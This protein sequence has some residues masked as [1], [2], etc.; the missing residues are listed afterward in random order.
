MPFLLKR[1]SNK[2]KSK[3]RCI[4]RPTISGRNSMN[5][6]FMLKSKAKLKTWVKLSK[7]WCNKPKLRW[8][9]LIT[10]A[11]LPSRLATSTRKKWS[12][13]LW[14]EQT[15][16]GIKLVGL[17]VSSM[18]VVSLKITT[19]RFKNLRKLKSE[20]KVLLNGIAS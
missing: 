3:N 10:D 12:K 16:I 20:L 8:T 9:R 13:I 2:D 18:E 1:K 14:R 7:L 5:L 6:T 17:Q 4:A 11:L 15:L 19:N